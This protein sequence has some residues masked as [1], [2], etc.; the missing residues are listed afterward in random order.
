LGIRICPFPPWKWV[1]DMLGRDKNIPAEPFTPRFL[2]PPTEILPRIGMGTQIRPIHLAL[3]DGYWQIVRP[4]SLPAVSHPA[5][6]RSAPLPPVPHRGEERESP[7]GTTVVA[8]L[9][10]Q[11]EKR[12]I[13]HCWTPGGFTD[14]SGSLASCGS[15]VRCLQPRIRCRNDGRAFL[16]CTGNRPATRRTGHLPPETR[17]RWGTPDGPVQPTPA[18]LAGCCYGTT[19]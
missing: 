6:P 5:F 18:P 15:A 2:K 14:P 1:W 7:W 3:G 8:I 10:W 13:L 11:E 12:S 4:R 17:R 16:G 19:R 9:L